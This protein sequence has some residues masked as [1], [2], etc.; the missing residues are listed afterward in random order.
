MALAARPQ[1]DIILRPSI[2][3]AATSDEPVADVVRPPMSAS[4]DPVDQ[5]AG[6]P[7]EI[8]P[9]E[10]A[11][12]IAAR[13]G[14]PATA[15]IKEPD[16]E[17]DKTE[18]TAQPDKTVKQPEADQEDDDELAIE[19]AAPGWAKKQVADIRKRAREKVAAIRAATQA[20]VGDEKWNE[21]WEA[22]N[23]N[24]TQKYREQLQTARAAERRAAQEKEALA[25][26]IEALKAT[27]PVVQEQP[28][29]DPRPN[30]DD[31][32][33]FE[34]YADALV[35]WGKRD[36]K[37]VN[38]A[39]QAAQRAEADRL[40][41][42]EK[43]QTDKEAKEAEE[44]ALNEENARI[45][46]DWQTKVAAAEEKYGDY[47]EVVMRSPEEGGPTVTPIMA[48]AMTRTDNGPDVAY[49]LANN[50]EESLRIAEL[51]N[52]ILQYGEIMK[53][54]GRLSAPQARQ[55]ARIPNPIKPIEAT[56]NDPVQPNPDDEDME[57]YAA[58]RLPQ[59]RRERHPFFPNVH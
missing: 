46:L 31:F 35:E 6:V 50:P 32:D 45:S 37:R 22:A 48:Q 27:Q 33:D 49:F 57:A 56:R 19:E 59:L 10:A 1:H 23:A 38:D 9:E 11:Q 20:E 26:E 14:D 43:A 51:Q 28:V 39:E 41:A 18:K 7:K 17:A 13:K 53:I 16:A 25:S 44:K 36:Q 21:A 30:R 15:E 3:L 54:S 55:R 4:A 2:P 52:P 8:S 5:A 58:R 47:N 40:A 34:V 42:A 29:V 24:V 12:Q